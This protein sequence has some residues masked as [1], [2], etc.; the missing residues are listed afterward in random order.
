MPDGTCARHSR[1]G[2]ET[3]SAIRA[4]N[5]ETAS[6]GVNLTRR[7]SARTGILSL[8]TLAFA[9]ACSPA[10]RVAPVDGTA[11]WSTYLGTPTR[12]PFVDQVV[13][14]DT[15][16]VL[17][18]GAVGPSI[19]GM[20]VAT[21]QVIVAASADRRIYAVSRL[22]GSRLW[23]VKLKG[24][25]LSPL[26]RADEIYAATDQHGALHVLHMSE[27]EELR[28]LRLPPVERTPALAGDTIYIATQGG[29]LYAFNP[30]SDEPA[31]VSRFRRSASAGPVV[32]DEWLIYVA[33]DSLFVLSRSSGQRRAA[34]FSSEV[35]TGEAASDGRAVYATT[36]LGSIIA[37]RLP[38]LQPLWHTSGFDPFI[39]GPAIAGPT[40]YA[41]TRTGSLLAFDVGDGSAEI[42]AD[43]AGIVR[44]TPVVVRNGVLVGDLEGRLHFFGR[45]G[46]PIWLVQF[47]GSLEIPVLVQGGGIVVPLYDR[48]GI[49][50]ASPTHGKLVELR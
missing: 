28:E 9:T 7:P 22:D 35:L 23:R 29:F 50:F 1:P 44:A 48:R 21:D 26:L 49:G 27:G 5:V 45:N 38:D 8:C 16:S 33:Y 46:E 40:G 4:P 12:A 36:E 47:D 18:I 39:A 41:A 43:A 25:P 34:A 17:W 37:W 42:I 2:A 32:V 31:W 15:P 30:R 11:Y 19:R 20:P 13:S 10:P 14:T 3:R 6:G 24:Q